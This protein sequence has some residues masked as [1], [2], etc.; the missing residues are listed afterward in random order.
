MFLLRGASLALAWFLVVNVVASVLVALV[1]T[2]AGRATAA[3]TES[4][5]LWLALRLVPAGVSMA[6][7]AGVFVPSYL[8][9]EPRQLTA[10]GLAITLTA[11][12]A[13]GLGLLVGG[14]VRA[15]AAWSRTARRAREWMRAAEPFELHDAP[16]SAYRIDAESPVMA[17]VGILRPKL[18]VTRGLLDALTAEELAA[19]VGHELGHSRGWDNLKRLAIAAAP[20]LLGA[21]GLARALEHRWAAAAEHCADR[22]ASATSPATRV[23]LASALVKVARL[24]PPPSTSVEPICTLIGL[25]DIAPRVERLIDIDSPLDRAP[26]RGAIVGRWSAALATAALLLVTYAHLAVGVHQVTETVIR[27]VP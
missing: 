7:V 23:A 6:F 3:S 20:D 4:P 12:G 8:E 25:G 15:V 1:A 18:L 22:R 11:L 10:E 26:R 24:M 17:L 16:I 14:G 27:F 21:M 13:V 19:T 2:R 9:F 5:S